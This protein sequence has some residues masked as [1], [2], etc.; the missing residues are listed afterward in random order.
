MRF[1]LVFFVLLLVPVAAGAQPVMPTAAAPATPAVGADFDGLAR[2]LEDPVSRDAFL[3]KVKALAAAQAKPKEADAEATFADSVLAGLAERRAVVAEVTGDVASSWRRLPDL[4]RWAGTVAANPARRWAWIEATLWLVFIFSL[5]VVAHGVA[6]RLWPLGRGEPTLAGAVA[7]FLRLAFAAGAFALAVLGLILFT[8]QTPLVRRT[9]L[10]LL[11]GITVCLVLLPFLDLL[12]GPTARARLLAVGDG[13]A[14][15]LQRG[16]K[17]AAL[18]GVLGTFILASAYDAGLPWTLHGF[19][20]RILYFVVTAMLIALILRLRALVSAAIQGLGGHGHTLSRIVSWPLVARAWPFAAIALVVMHYLVWAL[21][22]PGGFTFLFRA[23]AL[24]VLV[25]AGAR[26]LAYLADRAL[27]R[28]AHA[29][30][31]PAEDDEAEA[32]LGPTAG[33]AGPL[34]LLVRVLVAAFSL[35]LLL[36]VWQTGVI[37][38]VDRASGRSVAGLLTELAL[39]LLVTVALAQL[40]VHLFNRHMRAADAE[41]RLLHSNRSRTFASILKNLALVV[42]VGIAVLVTLSQL[43]VDAT[44]LLAGAGVVGLAIGFGSQ[45]LV[46]DLITG[47]FILVGDIARVGDV[48]EVGGRSG[49]I[50]GIS[51][52]AVQLR[53]YDGSVHAVPFSSIDIVTNMT[54]DF[55]FAVLEIGVAYRE[56]TD[57]VVEVLRGLDAEIR[58]EWP[59]RRLVLA[60]IE[61]AGVDLLGDSAVVVKARMKVRPGEQWTVKREM[62][63][64]IKLAFDARGIEIP[65]PHMTL[66]FGEGKDG[67]APPLHVESQA[68]ALRAAEAEARDLRAAETR[69]SGP[70]SVRA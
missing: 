49:V 7:G 56:S 29:G 30:P 62:L 1:V 8:D 6:R 4:V 52:R 64:R 65:Y 68:R 53:A 60:P 51:M 31:E 50:E 14:S 59:Y 13:V 58:R 27:P 26:L 28:P 3:A 70:Q 61:I 48:V 63:R 10:D 9:G 22:L 44:P 2:T 16:L 46:Q 21:R 55:S 41:G 32:A 35:V 25:L 40:I 34:R 20:Q 17:R 66:W 37:D 5:G 19:L 23:T 54:K 45:K 43:G 67:R 39:I 11:T 38:W 18:V 33:I 47:L 12:F 24:T 36:Q 69:P 15:L 42:L 57:Q